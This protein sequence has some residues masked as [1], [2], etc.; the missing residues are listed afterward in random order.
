[1]WDLGSWLLFIAILKSQQRNRRLLGPLGVFKLSSPSWQPVNKQRL[2]STKEP[3]LPKCW[4]YPSCDRNL[5]L[6][7]GYAL[8][9]QHLDEF[10]ICKPQKIP[11]LCNSN[12]SPL[13][14][15]DWYNLMT[16]KCVKK[17]ISQYQ[18]LHCL[19]QQQGAFQGVP[20]TRLIFQLEY[21]SMP[22]NWGTAIPNGI[23]RFRYQKPN[24]PSLLDWGTWTSR[25]FLAFWT[26]VIKWLASRT[27]LKWKYL[28]L[29]G[30]MLSFILVPNQFL[31]LCICLNS[32]QR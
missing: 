23:W 32:S 18:V 24:Y 17:I 10:G 14:G 28:V 27:W 6:L 22:M 21:K 1:M 13:L 7:L 30:L 25:H 11:Q 19:P 26:L 15:S 4:Y 12:M 20:A 2:L 8:G 3:F 5:I 9:L 16:V 31:G 29:L